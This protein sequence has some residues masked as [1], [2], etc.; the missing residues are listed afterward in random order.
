MRRRKEQD[1]AWQGSTLLSKDLKVNGI[2][3][4]PNF[5]TLSGMARGKARLCDCARSP[6]SLTRLATKLC[7]KNG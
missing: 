6:C 4:S 3:S 7:E 2:E 1:L 5:R